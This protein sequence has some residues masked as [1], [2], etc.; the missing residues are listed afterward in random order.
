MAVEISKDMRS[1][2]L[3]YHRLPKPG[4]LEVVATKPLGNQRDLA[5]AYSPG[6]AAAC[7]AIVE[8]PAEAANLTARQNLVAVISN[9]TAV[10]AGLFKKLPFDPRRDLAPVSLLGQFDLAVLVPEASPY[11]SLSELLAWGRA[12]PGKLNLGTIH[13][14]STQHLAAELFRSQANLSAQVIPYNGTPA[15]INALRDRKSVV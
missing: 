7:E 10:S 8:D 14:G 4:K 15:V 2:A 13:I 3:V 12:N 5:L 6:V 9:G 11:K 1:G